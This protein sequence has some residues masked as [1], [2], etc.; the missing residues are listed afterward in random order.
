VCS[1][2]LIRKFKVKWWNSSA[3][4]SK[5]S[6]PV[7]LR[8]LKENKKAEIKDLNPHSKFLAQKSHALALLAAA[9]SREEYFEMMKQL[10]QIDSKSNEFF[11]F[12]FRIHN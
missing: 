12:I 1:P 2:I 6:K 8:W 9:K 7:V 11:F 3:A 10:L 5:T 4:E